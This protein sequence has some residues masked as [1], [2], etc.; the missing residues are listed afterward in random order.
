[1]R[2]EQ[3][4]PCCKDARLF[5]PLYFCRF[6]RKQHLEARLAAD[7]VR[8]PGG[9][10]DRLPLGERVVHAVDRDLALT[11]KAG[12]KCIAARFV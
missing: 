2:L 6:S 3:A 10:D 8:V 9:H 7:G 11:V 1:M 5:V 4:P 12:D